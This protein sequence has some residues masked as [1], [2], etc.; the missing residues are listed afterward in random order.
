M[1]ELVWA[2][3]GYNARQVDQAGA[4]VPDLRIEIVKRSDDMTGFVVLPRRWVVERT[5]SW[6]GRNRRLPRTTKTSPTPCWPSLRWPPSRSPSADSRVGRLLSQALSLAYS[7]FAGPLS[8][9]ARRPGTGRVRQLSRVRLA[10]NPAR[11]V[12]S[13]NHKMRP[14]DCSL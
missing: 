2:D 14:G 6:F 12:A 5:F 9:F 11:L 4:K 13:D 7:N 3:G 10:L 8:A 1:V